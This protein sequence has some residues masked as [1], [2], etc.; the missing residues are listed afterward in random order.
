MDINLPLALSAVRTTTGG[1]EWFFTLNGHPVFPNGQNYGF[2][3][4]ESE[5][6]DAFYMV[7]RQWARA[8]NPVEEY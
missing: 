8:V 6:E 3:T 7:M 2:I 4:D 1:Q 5:P